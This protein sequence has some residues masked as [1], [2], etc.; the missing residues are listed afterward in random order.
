MR[1][2]L[3]VYQS[4]LGS[5]SGFGASIL[6]APVKCGGAESQDNV[7]GNN[8]PSSCHARHA[9]LQT[10]TISTRQLAGTCLTCEHHG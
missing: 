8:V 3:A 9:A 4:T 6:L 1:L 2:D 10:L 5:L 7:R